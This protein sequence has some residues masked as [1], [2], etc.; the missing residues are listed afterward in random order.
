MLPNEFV[1]VTRVFPGYRYSWRQFAGFN[2]C[3]KTANAIM[4]DLD[5]RSFEQYGEQPFVTTQV[6][7]DGAIDVYSHFVSFPRRSGTRYVIRYEI[8]NDLPS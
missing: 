4:S 2:N 3:K 8:I 6:I 5:R 7:T 1:T